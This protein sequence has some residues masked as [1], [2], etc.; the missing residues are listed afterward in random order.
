[1]K[2]LKTQSVKLKIQN[3]KGVVL[4]MVIVLSAVALAIMTALI[5]MITM[6]TQISGLQKRYKTALEAGEGGGNVFYQLIATRAEGAGVNSL[7]SDLNANGI[8]FTTQTTSAQCTVTLASGATYTGLQTKLMTPSNLWSPECNGG[9]ISIDPLTPST[10]DMKVE[11]GTSTKY[12]VYAKIVATTDG[13]S[14]GDLNL[15]TT[16][17]EGTNAGEVQVMSI[18]YLYAIEVV[19]E[20]GARIDE[21]AKISTLY[22]Y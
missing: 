21:R 19:S 3:E 6:G 8:N 10:Y 1:M 18:P 11:L 15:Q 14:G 4:I 17:V 16:G 9:F 2:E 12:T 20:N 13:N 22:Q 5:Y 7:T